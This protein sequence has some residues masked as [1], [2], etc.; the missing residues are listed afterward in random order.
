MQEGPSRTNGAREN[1]G[2]HLRRSAYCRSLTV[3]ATR[4]GV[5][6]WV[7][8]PKRKAL[9]MTT[10]GART[11][12]THAGARAHPRAGEKR[13]ERVPSDVAAKDEAGRAKAQ[14]PEEQL[15]EAI[16]L[17]GRAMAGVAARTVAQATDDLTLPQHRTLVVLA[18]QGPRHLADLA[19]A[20]GVSPSTATRMCDRLVRK[21]LITRTRDEVDRREVDLSLTNA[22]KA[23]VDEVAHRRKSELRKLVGDVPKDERDRLI[24]AL[25]SVA[26]AAG[27]VPDAD[28]T[29]GWS[30][31]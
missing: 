18:E 9:N 25:R 19:Q 1:A 23:L 24:E 31:S 21:R 14:T 2:T 5:N 12:T 20:L 3:I 17:A 28:W 29:L 30:E 4:R 11:R 26:E 8:S 22:G 7:G 6:V 16:I 27:A 15:A 13:D 10:A